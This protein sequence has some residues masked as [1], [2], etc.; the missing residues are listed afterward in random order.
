MLIHYTIS[1]TY[2]V[3]DG[4]AFVEGSENLVHLPIG[5]IVSIQP[6]IEIA[7]SMDADDHRDLDHEA[8]RAIGVRLEDYERTSIPH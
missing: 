8:G 6:V 1:G 2:A 7:I 3:P 4:S 5:Q